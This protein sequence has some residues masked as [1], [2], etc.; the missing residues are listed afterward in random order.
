MRIAYRML[1]GALGGLYILGTVFLAGYTIGESNLF[2]RSS[3]LEEIKREV[4]KKNELIDSLGVQGIF[5]SARYEIVRDHANDSN[6][7]LG[8]VNSYL[9][10]RN[11]S[12]RS[13]NL[14]PSETPPKH[15]TSLRE[16]YLK[17][18]LVYLDE[19]KRDP[20]YENSLSR[21]ANETSQLISD[22]FGVRV[23]FS[24]ETI[25]V[26]D[27][28]RKEKGKLDEWVEKNVKLDDEAK[29]ILIYEEENVG[30]HTTKYNQTILHAGECGYI[31]N[32]CRVGLPQL[33]ISED[34]VAAIAGTVAQEVGHSLGLPHSGD[35]GIMDTKYT[36]VKGVGERSKRLAT[37]LKDLEWSPVH[38]TMIRCVDGCKN[39]QGFSFEPKGTTTLSKEENQADINSQLLQYLITRTK[40]GL[41]GDGIG[42]R[43][44]IPN[45]AEEEILVTVT[46]SSS[47]HTSELHFK[48]KDRILV[49]DIVA[50]T[51]YYN[52]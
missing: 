45:N 33:P 8:D 51:T 46:H 49:N 2:R 14:Y 13:F 29:N 48:V 50:Q 23:D 26:P 20:G 11:F 44:L 15:L 24:V 5:E 30:R 7:Y 36:G 40:L 4:R 25:K 41:V 32:A 35:K 18:A 1:L 34:V 28:V 22:L 47:G 27:N 17:I 31:S 38:T 19:D 9:Q 37:V 10:R 16:G 21:I 6:L 39:E 12:L 52:P 43:T 3:Q 42:V